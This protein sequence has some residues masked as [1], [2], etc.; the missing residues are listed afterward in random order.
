MALPSCLVHRLPSVAVPQ[1]PLTGVRT[2]VS[3]RLVL[4]LGATDDVIQPLLLKT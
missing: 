3:W 4:P 1:D 2:K